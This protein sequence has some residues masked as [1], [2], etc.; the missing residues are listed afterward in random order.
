MDT[1]IIEFSP[2]DKSKVLKAIQSLGNVTGN[3]GD[4][5]LLLATNKPLLSIG[6]K[7]HS[8]NLEN[9]FYIRMRVD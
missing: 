8:A 3:Y 1:V 5:E 2:H 9:G 4:S 6:R 7:L